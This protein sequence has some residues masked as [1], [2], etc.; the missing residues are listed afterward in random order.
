[1]AV[2]TTSMSL[3]DTAD[4]GRP[5]LGASL[6]LV[7]PSLKRRIHLATVRYDSALSPYTYSKSAFTTELC[8]YFALYPVLF[9]ANYSLCKDIAFRSYT[10]RT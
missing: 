8:A 2:F 5:A 1:M 9:K 4:S 10:T 3:P 7:Q 6:A